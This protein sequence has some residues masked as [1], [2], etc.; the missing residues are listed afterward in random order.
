MMR[1]MID[2]TKNH[3][4]RQDETKSRPAEPMER[5][6]ATSSENDS[7]QRTEVDS[8]CFRI[9]GRLM[10]IPIEQV[11]E[12]VELPPISHLFHL[13]DWVRGLAP[14]RGD[15]LLVLDLAGL[16]DLP[17]TH[18]ET[19]RVLVVRSKAARWGVVVDDILGVRKLTRAQGGTG[20]TPG[21]PTWSEGL[22]S[23][24]NSP[25]LVLDMDRLAQHIGSMVRSEGPDSPTATGGDSE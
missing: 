7:R 6:A 9:A 15:I 16:F 21:V 4:P 24:G 5:V 18:S 11:A 14:L 12:A 2:G 8:I 25:V 23:D 22:F 19:S 3:E 17:G 13:P 10:A 20:R 1:A